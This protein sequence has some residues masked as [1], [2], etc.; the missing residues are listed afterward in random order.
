MR[1]S[2][3]V[4]VVAVLGLALAAC[5]GTNSG[6]KG[7]AKAA[8]DAGAGKWKTYVLSSASDVTVPPPPSGPAASAEQA[9]V[10]RLAQERTPAIEDAVKRWSPAV[11]LKPWIDLNMELVAHGGVKDP[12]SASR[13]YALTSV[14]IYDALVTAWKWK[15]QY[16]RKPPVGVSTLTP[17]GATPSYPSEH[18]AM[19][20]AAAVVLAYAFPDEPVGTFDDLAKQAGESRV[21]AGVNFRS[22]VDAGLA[23]GRAIG[24]KVLVRAKA[25]GSDRKWDG[26]RP[27]GIGG[28]PQYWDDP[29][30]LITP[31]VKPLA[32]SWKPWVITSGNQFRPGAPAAYGSPQ[33]LTEAR[34]VLDIT[35]NLNDAQKAIASFWAGG[36]GTALPPGLWN[37]VALDYVSRSNLSTP[38]AARVIAALNVGEAD[39]AIAVW[40]TKFTYW[41]PRPLNAIRDLGLDSTF[42][43]FLGTPV[44]P[45]YVSGH[46]GF[47]G[48]AAEILSYFFP[49]D[50]QIFDAKAQEA[51]MSRLYG[52]I[53]YRSD[54]E[55][56]LELGHK[57]GKAVVDRVKKDGAGA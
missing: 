32:G 6:A 23:L 56:G 21:Q 5:N 17:A 3:L 20:G 50:A 11:A 36:A 15:Y 54:N 8:A 35:K 26:T 51:A 37:Q 49:S 14:A 30:G 55:V 39:A 13:S 24:E 34:E 31:P 4:S 27:A 16:N 45:S 47:S 25:D 29:P 22:D 40:D 41:S 33:F 10:A 46:A 1:R 19:A 7:A 9:E 42:K 43:P 38:Q 18:A 28:A 53:H 52:G 12:P 44:F 48:A 57:V 2:R